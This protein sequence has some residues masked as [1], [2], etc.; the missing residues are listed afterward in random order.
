MQLRT[1]TRQVDESLSAVATLQDAV[2]AVAQRLEARLDGLDIEAMGSMLDVFDAET[3][4]D[5]TVSAELVASWGTTRAVI[6]GGL[7][8]VGE[9]LQR[10][11]TLLLESGD[12]QLEEIGQT[13]FTGDFSEIFGS[14]QAA[15]VAALDNVNG[16]STVRAYRSAL[17]A[18]A[19]CLDAY[20]NYLEDSERVAVCDAMLTE[21]SQPTIT[22]ILTGPLDDGIT[23]IVRQ[24]ALL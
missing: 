22:S 1:L 12:P 17:E 14:P 21:T 3:A 15:L 23:E 16:Q 19:Q 6:D 11:H 18:V 13:Y 4:P 24:L 9:G 10:L 2:E 5:P 7:K 8:T 20:L